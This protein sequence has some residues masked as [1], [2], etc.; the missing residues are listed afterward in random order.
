MCVFTTVAIIAAM[1]TLI[2]THYQ[3]V[4]LSFPHFLPP[5]CNTDTVP[6][7]FTSLATHTHTSIFIFFF[8]IWHSK[9]RVEA[10]VGVQLCRAVSVN[11]LLPIVAATRCTTSVSHYRTTI[12]VNVHQP[13]TNKHDGVERKEECGKGKGANANGHPRCLRSSPASVFRPTNRPLLLI[14]MSGMLPPACH[15]SRGYLTVAVTQTHTRA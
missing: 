8:V 10:G 7:S 14:M 15:V 3:T 13:Q 4:L 5:Y 9:T 12:M 6:N 1:L 11:I 2:G